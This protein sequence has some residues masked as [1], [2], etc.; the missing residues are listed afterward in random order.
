MLLNLD[1][2][3]ESERQALLAALRGQDE[4]YATERKRQLMLS[5]LKLDQKRIADEN[6]IQGAALVFRMSEMNNEK[7]QARYVIVLLSNIK[8]F[9]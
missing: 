4:R 5:R 9:M 8:I 1:H 2:D 3:Y 6:Q 7:S